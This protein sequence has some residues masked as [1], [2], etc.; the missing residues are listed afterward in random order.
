MED[1]SDTAFEKKISM[2]ASSTSP[3]TPV[4][5][6]RKISGH[7]DQIKHGRD[8]QLLHQVLNIYGILEY[9]AKYWGNLIITLQ[10]NNKQTVLNSSNFRQK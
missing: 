6:G 9:N 10:L 8:K 7:Y 1:K 5:N 3:L 4:H 2:G